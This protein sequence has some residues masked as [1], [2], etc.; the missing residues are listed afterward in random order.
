MKWNNTKVAKFGRPCGTGNGT[1]ISPQACTNRVQIIELIIKSIPIY[2][3]PLGIQI[4]D[5]AH[6][7]LPTQAYYGSSVVLTYTFHGT[8]HSSSVSFHAESVLQTSCSLSLFESFLL[9]KPD[10]PW[11]DVLI[12]K[13]DVT[14]V[15]AWCR[16]RSLTSISLGSTFTHCLLFP[17]LLLVFS[18]FPP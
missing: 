8:K 9:L 5:Q 3:F 7:N 13:L 16:P 1:G 14:R 11:L 18:P 17:A 10:S 4:Q 15:E 6:C 12:A 2:S